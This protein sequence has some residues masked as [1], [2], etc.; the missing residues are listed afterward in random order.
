MRATDKEY[1]EHAKKEF[2]KKYPNLREFMPFL[3]AL[4]KESHRG[5]VLIS[6]S[7]IDE[8]LRQIILAYML[9]NPESLKLLVGYNAPSGTFSARVTAAYSLALISEIEYQE[10]NVLRKIRNEFAHSV[11]ASFSDQN[12]IDLCKGLHFSAKDYADVVVD[13]FGHIYVLL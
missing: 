11:S 1:E 7:Y 12:I 9:N 4:N 10:C 2:L 5:A 13:S 3:D 8:Q 6:C